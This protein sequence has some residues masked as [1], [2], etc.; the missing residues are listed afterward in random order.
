VDVA[1]WLERITDEAEALARAA[2]AGPLDARVPG[3]PQWNVEALV[4]HMGDVHRWAGHI[5]RERVPERLR[6]DFHGPA[7]REGLLAWYR[8]GAVD[9]VDALRATSPDDVFW[10]WGPGPNALAFWSRRQANETSM[11]RW[12]AESARGAARP[13]PVDVALDALDEWLGLLQRRTHAPGGAGRTVHLHATD[14]DGEWLVTLDEA[15]TVERGHARGDCAVRAPASDLYL[16]AM[17]RRTA[18][19]LEMFGDESL[20]DTWR[21]NIRF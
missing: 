15:I 6:R 13:F 8:A 7:D 2:E 11:H 5:V 12:D 17:N 18:K 14:G 9:L 3:C 10:Y 16:L 1:S 4:R 19:G 21:D 20:L